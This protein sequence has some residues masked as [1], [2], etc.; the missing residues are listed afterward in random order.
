MIYGPVEVL[1]SDLHLERTTPLIYSNST[2]AADALHSY[3][4]RK[5]GGKEI[6]WDGVNYE[7]ITHVH[8]LIMRWI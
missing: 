5:K 7:C 6:M 8:L 1:L 4:T 3:I 2:A